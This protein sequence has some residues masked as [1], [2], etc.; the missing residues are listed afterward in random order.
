VLALASPAF[1]H[2]EIT[3]DDAEAGQPSTMTV[4]VPNEMDKAGTN[5]VELAFPEGQTLT[6]VTVADTPGWTSTVSADRIT[7]TGGPLTGQDEVKL[8]FTATLPAGA[9]TLEFRALQTYDN[10][11]TVRWIEPTPPGGPEPDHPAPVLT[12]GAT[13]DGDHQAE[14]G[15]DSTAADHNEASD[16]SD[17]SDN[18]N[19]TVIAVV[20]IAVIVLA[21]GGGAVIYMRRRRTS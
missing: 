5:K 18:S 9:T 21:A 10:G 4:T 15:T 2:V 8:T 12:I 19:G 3:S 11:V 14:Q 6:D 17:S 16:T 1:A 7:W 13:A 20:V